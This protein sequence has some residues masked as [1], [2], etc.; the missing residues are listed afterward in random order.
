MLVLPFELLAELSSGDTWTR[1]SVRAALF[2]Y[3]LAGVL[4]SRLDRAGWAARTRPGRLARLA[5]SLGCL[6]Y[7]LHVALAFHYFHG[8]SHTEAVRHVEEVSGF[9]PGLF[10]SYLFT[11][12]WAADVA[13][14]WLSPVSY[15]GRPTWIGL[16][17]HG[18]F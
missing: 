1:L 9:G 14:W 7:L 4:M 16:T 2:F 3:A 15:A 13:W 18:F 5:W 10:V 17:W 12:A 11:L 8:W 6:A